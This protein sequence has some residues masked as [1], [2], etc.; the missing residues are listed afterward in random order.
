VNKVVIVE[1]SLQLNVKYSP[2]FLTPAAQPITLTYGVDI[3]TELNCETAE[4][5][6]VST[7]F[8]FFTSSHSNVVKEIKN[9]NASKLSVNPLYMESD[10]VYECFVN[11]GIGIANRKF[12]VAVVPKGIFFQR[13]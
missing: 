6:K 8:W 1:D 3:E 7:I 2:K 4:N 11:N 13:L 5:P 9:Q 10:G 12:P